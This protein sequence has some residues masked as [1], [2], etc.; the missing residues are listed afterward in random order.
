MK[1][2]SLPWILFWMC[3]LAVVVFIVG[4]YIERIS[5]LQGNVG[6]LTERVN[7]L[8]MRNIRHDAHW[9]WVSWVGSRIS[10]VKC[11]FNRE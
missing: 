9:G 3:F 2:I 4:R 7:Q 1:A 5:A 6:D 8:E 10:L 11:F